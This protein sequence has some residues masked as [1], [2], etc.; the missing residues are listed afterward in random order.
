MLKLD[1]LSLGVLRAWIIIKHTKLPSRTSPLI[2]PFSA[3][4]VLI[5]GGFD[6][7]GRVYGD[8]FLFNMNDK[9]VTK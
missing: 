4:E 5:A 8:G 2:A 7:D 1:K 6:D 3:T 9:S